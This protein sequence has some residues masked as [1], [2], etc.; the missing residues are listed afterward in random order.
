MRKTRRLTSTSCTAGQGLRLCWHCGTSTFPLGAACSPSSQNNPGRQGCGVMARVNHSVCAKCLCA[1]ARAAAK[2]KPK[3]SSCKGHE[4]RPGTLDGA[5]VV[6]AQSIDDLQSGNCSSAQDAQGQRFRV[7]N[8]FLRAE[9]KGQLSQHLE[10]GAAERPQRCQPQLT[11]N[12]SRCLG[13]IQACQ[14][15]KLKLKH[16]HIPSFYPSLAWQGWA[17]GGPRTCRP[18]VCT[19]KRGPENKRYTKTERVQSMFKVLS[20]TDRT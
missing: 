1:R 17:F 6:F 19:G 11:A 12:C 18:V 10:M 4:P 5:A 9:S 15:P 14:K 16:R 20:L 3:R 7:D 2:R 8:G 13:R